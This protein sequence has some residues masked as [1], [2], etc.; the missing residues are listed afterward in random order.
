MAKSP[1]S[2]NDYGYTQ[3]YS[4]PKKGGMPT[5]TH[6]NAKSSVG[7]NWTTSDQSD[8]LTARSDT[9]SMRTK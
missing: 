8:K 9:P 3:A 2:Q 1:S 5:G 7:K 6:G 4:A